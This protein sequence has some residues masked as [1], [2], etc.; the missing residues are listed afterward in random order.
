MDRVCD[1]SAALKD[2]DRGQTL[3]EIEEKMGSFYKQLCLVN[4]LHRSSDGVTIC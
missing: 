4:V 1:N 3:F 2:T